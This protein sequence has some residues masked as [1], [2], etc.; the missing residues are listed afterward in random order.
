MMGVFRLNPFTMHNA[1]G[2][3]GVPMPSW[4][5]EDA[6]PLEEEPLLYE[7]QLL[8]ENVALETDEVLRSFSPDFEIGGVEE[9]GEW[10]EDYSHHHSRREPHRHHYHHH[11]YHS[12]SPRRPS[13]WDQS[14]SQIYSS[15]TATS[16]SLDLEYPDSFTDQQHGR[17]FSPFLRALHL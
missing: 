9:E 10:Q 12:E 2:R 4:N 8:L 11:H 3:A 7:F 5:G 16:T 6:G 15:P 1:G 13:V 17:K 14:S